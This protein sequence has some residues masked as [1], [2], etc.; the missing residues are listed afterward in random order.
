MNPPLALA[1][2]LLPF[3][4]PAAQA[5]DAEHT[6]WIRAS[7]RSAIATF[8]ASGAT[9]LRKTVENCY[10]GA[11]KKGD[12]KSFF[13]EAERCTAMDHLGRIVF[14]DQKIGLQD[15]GRPVNDS[16]FNPVAQQKRLNSFWNERQMTE[17]E[18][19]DL[20]EKIY[21]VVFDES[22]NASA[23]AAAKTPAPKTKPK[24]T[25]KTPTP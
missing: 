5:Q 12:F 8:A 16:F 13:L 24:P 22:R 3:F 2:F 23:V 15:S 21:A 17:K 10:A 11:D 9:G 25:G 6:A 20:T 19:D 4:A 7:T 14:M 18:K 1:V